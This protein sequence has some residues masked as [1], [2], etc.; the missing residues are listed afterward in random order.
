ML[1]MLTLMLGAGLR[2]GFGFWGGGKASAERQRESHNNSDRNGIASSFFFCSIFKRCG[3]QENR[4]DATAENIY[5][6]FRVQP[7]LS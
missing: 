5:E 6:L 4:S 2:F 7:G 3:G 1:Q